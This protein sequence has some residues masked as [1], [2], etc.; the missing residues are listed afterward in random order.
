MC[1]HPGLQFY[2]Y[3][4]T[5]VIPRMNLNTWH[6]ITMELLVNVPTTCIHYIIQLMKLILFL[7]LEKP[8]HSRQFWA[9]SESRLYVLLFHSTIK[10]HPTK[11]NHYSQG[12]KTSLFPLK[13]P[14]RFLGISGQ[15]PSC[16]SKCN[17]LHVVIGFFSSLN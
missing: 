6:T 11:I 16:V 9:Q 12:K 5:L 3:I 2:T 14:G 15:N 17:H 7:N 8:T 4:H 1:C 13:C 10:V